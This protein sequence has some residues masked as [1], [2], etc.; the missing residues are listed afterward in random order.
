MPSIQ[1]VRDAILYRMRLLI[2]LLLLCSLDLMASQIV[3]SG[4]VVNSETQEPI[5]WVG[6]GIVEKALGTV[7]DDRGRFSL[8][9]DRSYQ[10]QFLSFSH[11]N[12]ESARII[13]STSAKDL[14]IA[15]TPKPMVKLPP[16]DLYPS[17]TVVLGREKN[18]KSVH[19][20]FKVGG[21]GG[22]AGTLIRNDKLC[23]LG[24][25]NMNIIE[26]QMG[27]LTFRLNFYSV[28]NGVPGEKLPKDTFFVI[29][30]GFSGLLSLNL[31][32]LGVVVEAD[33]IATIELLK[34]ENQDAEQELKF[35][36][37]IGR[38]GRVYSKLISLD[39]WRRVHKKVGLCFWLDADI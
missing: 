23:R 27:D 30:K 37:Y 34:I 12:F 19:A 14:T 29:S 26:N 4:T 18:H 7:S 38:K 33:F 13:I 2:V 5:P 21:L 9:I 20:F 10:G 28:E 22:E 16:I 35:S 31:Q 15:M 24:T 17:K 1:R 3:V 25:F 11:L 32:P 39:A 8:A 6:I 36:A